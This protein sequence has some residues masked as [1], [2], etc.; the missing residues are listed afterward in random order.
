[1]IKHVQ[2]ESTSAKEFSQY[3]QPNDTVAES[4]NEDRKVNSFQLKSQK[5]SAVNS[6]FDTESTEESK[7]I[8]VCLQLLKSPPRYNYDIEYSKNVEKFLKK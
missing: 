3:S 8:K 1:M 7:G 5:P 6:S 4:S 2:E